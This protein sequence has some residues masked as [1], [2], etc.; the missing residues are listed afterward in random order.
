MI[1]PRVNLLKKNEIRYQG[2]VSWNFILLCGIGTPVLLAL[3]SIGLCFIRSVSTKSELKS[4][5]TLWENYEPRLAV[6]KKGNQC[7]V[8][9]QKI[10]DLFEDW[11]RSTVSFVT[12]LDDVQAVVPDA[13]QFTRMSIRSDESG[14]LY[15]TEGELRLDYSMIIEGIAQGAQAENQVISFQKDLL[16]CKE[17]GAVF[18]SLKLASLRKKNGCARRE[19]ERISFDWRV[20]G[21]RCK[22]NLSELTKNQKQYILLGIIIAGVAISGIVIGVKFSISTMNKAK[23]ELADLN[24]KIGRAE[25][26]LS[27]STK[28][29]DDFE[30]SIVQLEEYL[31]HVTPGQNYYSWATEI[32]YSTGRKA[33]LEIESVDEIGMSSSRK[34]MPVD[35]VYLEAYSL[36]ITAR[37]GFRQI[38]AFLRD[39]EENHPLVRFLGA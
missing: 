9:N 1:Y 10:L 14:S 28:T 27:K 30:Q 12:L 6:H 37:G 3:L 8:T 29:R 21:R 39:I 7:L 25:K 24:N 32:V 16:T 5:H 22:V 4:S 19:H 34:G 38:K 11:E 23:V 2:V 35:S 20:T 18:D 31:D 15:K 26:A 33:G 17:V 36:R 13:V